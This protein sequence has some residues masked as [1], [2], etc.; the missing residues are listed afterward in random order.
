MFKNPS[1]VRGAKNESVVNNFVAYGVIDLKKELSGYSN[2]ESVSVKSLDGSS[3]LY[4][5]GDILK[6]LKPYKL[7]SKARVFEISI[8]FNDGRVMNKVVRL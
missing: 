4:L 8:K 3:S 2:L 6:K 7:S 5:T 1:Q